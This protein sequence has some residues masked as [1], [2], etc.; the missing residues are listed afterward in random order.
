GGRL[1]RGFDYGQIVGAVVH[2]SG[3]LPKPGTVSQ[4]GGFLYPLGELDGSITPRLQ[5][6]S[7]MFTQ[8]GLQAPPAT[9]IRQ[10]VWRKLMGNVSLNPVS[11]L[12]RSMIGPMFADSDIAGVIRGLME[13]CTE[14]ASAVGIDVGISIEDRMALAGRLVDVK[15]SMLQDMEA[16]RPLEIEP[17][18]GA[19]VELSQLYEIATP[20]TRL[21]YALLRALEKNLQSR[22]K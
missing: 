4:S 17:I 3:H 13:E 2:A 16:G 19:V 7:E 22:A 6:L 9:N 21:I 10:D 14:L 5:A 8:A 18:V 1:L 12:T 20:K 15:T 11:V